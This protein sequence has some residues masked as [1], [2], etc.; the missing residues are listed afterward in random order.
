MSI[1][2]SFR[3]LID[4]VLVQALRA[5]GAAWRQFDWR[6]GIKRG[7][8]RFNLVTDGFWGFMPSITPPVRT[9][10]LPPSY[11]VTSFFVTSMRTRGG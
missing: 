8:V 2:L 6:V 4:V 11:G 9:V 1:M 3:I 5:V 10:V 7:A